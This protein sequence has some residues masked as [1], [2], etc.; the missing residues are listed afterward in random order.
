MAGRRELQGV[1]AAVYESI[2][3]R[4]KMQGVQEATVHLWYGKQRN[5]NARNAEAAVV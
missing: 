5:I 2:A 4:V 1:R 3:N